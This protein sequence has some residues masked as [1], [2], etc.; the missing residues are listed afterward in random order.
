MLNDDMDFQGRYR[1]KFSF[2]NMFMNIEVVSEWQHNIITDVGRA[3]IANTLTG[4]SVNKIQGMAVGTGTN[5]AI[6]GDTA[7]GAETVRKAVTPSVA[8][9]NMTF[10]AGFTI[11]E[12]NGT[13][14][15]GLTTNSSSGGIL[16]TRSVYSNGAINLPSGALSIDYVIETSNGS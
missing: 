5:S 12:I 13:T 14:E 9:G 15:V 2:Q 10:N 4:L 16:V 3:M 1:F 7:L 6:A 11:S 8:N